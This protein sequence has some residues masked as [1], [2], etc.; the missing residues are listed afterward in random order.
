MSLDQATSTQQLLIGGEWKDA[1]SGRK[2]SQ[3]FPYTGEE[4]GT[5]A[6]A[7]REDARSAVDAAW[8]AFAD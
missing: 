4:V 5:A 6:A 1:V 2:F 8:A 3:N 7:G